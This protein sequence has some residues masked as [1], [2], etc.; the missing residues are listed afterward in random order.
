MV[1][2]T[3]TIANVPR[4]A[5][6][7]WGDTPT[8]RPPTSREPRWHDAAYVRT[9]NPYVASAKQDESSPHVTLCIAYKATIR[10]KVC[11]NR[12]QLSPISIDLALR[13]Y[14]AFCLNQLTRRQYTLQCVC[15][16]QTPAGVAR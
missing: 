7:P 5:W 1:C 14:D 6:V 12:T 15:H 3:T 2:F 11:P 13:D 4:A 10:S 16:S 9:P 8:T